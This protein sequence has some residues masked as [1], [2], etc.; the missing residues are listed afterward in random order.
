MGGRVGGALWFRGLT[1]NGDTADVGIDDV[2]GFRAPNHLSLAWR[3]ECYDGRI[4][5][6][7]LWIMRDPFGNVICLGVSG[8]SRG[9]VYF[10][11]HESELEDE[12]NGSVESAG[13]IKLLA[14]DFV[15]FVAHLVPRTDDAYLPLGRTRDG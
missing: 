10:W 6:D 8:E 9:K 5:D 3:R 15:A 14:N 7:L 12:W 1:P 13:N 11:D 2:G 4:P